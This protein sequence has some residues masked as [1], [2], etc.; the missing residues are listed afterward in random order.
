VTDV[1][2]PAP[3][4]VERAVDH[5][6]DGRLP[7]RVFDPHAFIEALD[8]ILDPDCGFG[9]LTA[10]ADIGDRFAPAIRQYLARPTI[11]ALDRCV[12]FDDFVDAIDRLG[13]EDVPCSAT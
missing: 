2:L 4:P 5:L 6:C 7:D 8:L 11:E 10:L 13:Q 12:D 3:G 1:A 9:H